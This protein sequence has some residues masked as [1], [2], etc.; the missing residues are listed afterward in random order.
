MAGCDGDHRSKSAPAE[1]R[2]GK[3]EI[4]ERYAHYSPFPISFL[5]FRPS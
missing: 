1:A 3:R 4:L 2:L 5:K